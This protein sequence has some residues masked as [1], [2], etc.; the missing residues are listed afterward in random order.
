MLIVCRMMV[1]GCWPTPPAETAD[2]W[3]SPAPGTH[4]LPDIPTAPAAGPK[5][6]RVQVPPHSSAS[7][8]WQAVPYH[9][10]PQTLPEITVAA[11]QHGQAV[12]V[13]RGCSMFVHRQSPRQEVQ[14]TP[15]PSMEPG[16]V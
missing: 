13:T 2:T 16:M 1:Y 8:S 11:A 4:S 3:H 6:T 7:L 5:S 15:E 14:A 10:G 12:D 9:S